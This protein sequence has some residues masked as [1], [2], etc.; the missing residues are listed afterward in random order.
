MT[1]MIPASE[2]KTKFFALLQKVMNKD[3]EV[4]VTKN[5]KPAAVLI[6]YKE[7]E[8]ILETMELLSD[9]KAMKRIRE[10]REYIKKGG[11]LLTHEEVFGELLF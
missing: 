5:G 2:V 1:K 6:N 9:P 7:F 4:I 3:Q 11:R 10:A 8:S